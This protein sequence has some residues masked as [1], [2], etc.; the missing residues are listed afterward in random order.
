[1][2]DAGELL[3]VLYEHIKAT[4]SPAAAAA[5]D[6]AFGLSVSESVWCDKCGKET[7][8]SQYTQVGRPAC[9][10]CL[11]CTPAAATCST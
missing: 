1:M 11:T 3:L 6:A 4:A 10:T 7:Q 8:Q 2:S 5:V 9:L